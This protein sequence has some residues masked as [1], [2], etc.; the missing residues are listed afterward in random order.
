M[1]KLESKPVADNFSISS[2]HEDNIISPSKL[3]QQSIS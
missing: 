2:K 3:N 1:E